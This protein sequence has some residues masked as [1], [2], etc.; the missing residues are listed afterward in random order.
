MSRKLRHVVV[1][2][3]RIRGRLMLYN[4]GVIVMELV[5]GQTYAGSITHPNGKWATCRI[6]GGRHSLGL[7][8]ANCEKKRREEIKGTRK[9]DN[10]KGI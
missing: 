5:P 2:V 8:C 6:C 9:P 7:K 10:I 4:D 1:E 3:K